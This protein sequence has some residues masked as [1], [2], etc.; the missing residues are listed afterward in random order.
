LSRPPGARR[1]QIRL[2]LDC[3]ANQGLLD[4]LAGGGFVVKEFT[5]ADIL[6]RHRNARCTGVHSGAGWLWSGS[7]TIVNWTR[8]AA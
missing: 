3:L 5:L 6:G 2:A 7:L 8:Y 1:T 4:V